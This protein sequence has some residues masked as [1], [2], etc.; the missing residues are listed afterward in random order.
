MPYSGDRVSFT[1]TA[2]VVSMFLVEAV[3]FRSLFDIDSWRQLRSQRQKH[4]QQL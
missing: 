1:Y 3:S 2:D 4:L